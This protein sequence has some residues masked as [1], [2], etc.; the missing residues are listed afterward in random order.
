MRK[1]YKSLFVAAAFAML[2]PSQ[3]MAQHPSADS[4]WAYGGRIGVSANQAALVNWAAGGENTFGLNL[5]LDYNAVLTTGDHLWD[6]RVEFEYGFTNTETG[7]NKKNSDKI[8]LSSVYGYKISENLYL[9]GSLSFRTQ[10]AKGFNYTP[11]PAVMISNFMSPGYLT[12]GAGI[13]WT[14]K[15]WI[16][17]TLTPVTYRGIFVFDKELSDA[18]QFGVSPG[19]NYKTELGA[20]LKV[21]LQHDIMENVNLFSR[22]SLFSDYL[23]DPQNVDVMWDVKVNMKINKWLSANLST[24]LIYDHDVKITDSKSLVGPRVQFQELLG[25]G[26]SIVL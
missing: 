17:A 20:N 25:V 8:Y 10:F 24:S 23:N 14:P 6:N 7:G 5:H 22:V 2:L 16:T 18:G 13:T 26:I 19:S 4:T 15:S 12:A 9:S 11:T 1:I 3:S 21:E